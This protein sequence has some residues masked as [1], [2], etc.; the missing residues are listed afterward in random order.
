MAV[1]ALALDVPIGEEHA[2]DGIVEL[3]DRLR[4][5]EASG[6]EAPVDVL[7][8]RDVLRRVGRVP[9]IE[10][11]VESLQILG[12]SRRDPRHELLRADS[13]GLRLEHDRRAVR[14]V[15]AH[16]MHLIALHALEAHPDVRLD[17][18]HDVP[19][20]KRAVGVG[21]RRRDEEFLGHI[22][23]VY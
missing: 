23:P 2:L 21:E 3:L 4:V 15:R 14:V 7:R 22:L 5:D 9:M 19:D 18:L 11:E 8:Q 17:V 13:F 12:P 6:L 20:V 1:R 10:A 16:E